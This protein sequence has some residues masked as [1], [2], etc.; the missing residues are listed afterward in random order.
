MQ[1]QSWFVLLLHVSLGSA[2]YDRALTVFSPQ[3]E[4]LQVTYAEEAA[5]RGSPVAA[6]SN[7]RDCIALCVAAPPWLGSHEDGGDQEDTD[8]TNSS[9]S[10]LANSSESHRQKLCKVDEHVWLAFAG[11]SADGRVLVGK[12]RLECQQYRYTYG[13]APPVEHVTRFVSEMQHRYTRLGGARPFGVSCIVVGFDEEGHPRV[14][15]N[16]PSGS[17]AEWRATATGK[18]SPKAMEVLEAKAEGL[19]GSS[20]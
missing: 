20:G 12:V 5:R 17:F 6:A 11:L 14:F 16:D 8:T 13:T 15:R 1:L 18:D 10:L 9:L 19:A 4:L 3:G 2:M 7:G